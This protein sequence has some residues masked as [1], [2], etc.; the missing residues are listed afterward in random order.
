MPQR[1]N[2]SKKSGVGNVSVI[3]I[4]HNPSIPTS[5]FIPFQNMRGTAKEK[6]DHLISNRDKRLKEEPI[7]SPYR[8]TAFC[9]QI[10]SSINDADLSRLGY[11]NHCHKNFIKTLDRCQADQSSTEN[12]EVR[13]RS[14]CK[15]KSTD[16]LFP[17][18]CTF[19]GKKNRCND[20]KLKKCSSFKHRDASWQSTEL[21]AL[22]IGDTQLQ[23]LVQ[24]QDLFAR[25]AQY[26]E[27]CENQ[28]KLNYLN[29]KRL[30]NYFLLIQNYHCRISTAYQNA[31]TFLVH[32]II[33]Y[34][35]YYHLSFIMQIL[36]LPMQ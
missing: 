6:L 25:E 28:F 21:R 29:M 31:L 26:N 20:S 1:K 34:N 11:Q 16:T 33:Y 4:I 3:C 8:M 14:P 32:E 5:Q 24:G 17:A 23:Q 30:V 35:A 36:Q 9:A 7:E 15:K 2:V 10:S 18:E 22:E 13:N 19:C 27:S 12:E